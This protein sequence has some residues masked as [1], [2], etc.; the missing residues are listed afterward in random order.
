MGFLFWLGLA[1]GINVPVS[2][3]ALVGVEITWKGQKEAEERSSDLRMP[4]R[5]NC[6]GAAASK[7]R[8]SRLCLGAC[9]GNHHCLDYH[10]PRTRLEAPGRNAEGHS[11]VMHKKQSTRIELPCPEHIPS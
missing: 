1:L 9:L 2:G 6:I 7:L 5:H 11:T 8:S 3:C 4:C 10:S